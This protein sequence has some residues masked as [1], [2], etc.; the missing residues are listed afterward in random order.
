V[1]RPGYPVAAASEQN[2]D[3]KNRQEHHSDQRST[4]RGE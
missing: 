4:H 1:L 2:D 3:G